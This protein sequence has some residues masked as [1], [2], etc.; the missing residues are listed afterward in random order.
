MEAQVTWDLG[1]ELGFQVCT[2]WTMIKALLKVSEVQDFTLP[3]KRGHPRKNK[4][5]VEGLWGFFPCSVGWVGWLGS[6]TSAFV[7][8][9]V[10][11]LALFG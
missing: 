2:E 10:L 3:R 5:P 8:L 1:K 11:F 7:Y 6:R 4:R 9:R